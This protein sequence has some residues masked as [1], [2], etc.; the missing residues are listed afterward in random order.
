MLIAP[1]GLCFSAQG[2][3]LTHGRLA[4]M[5]PLSRHICFAVLAS[6]L[7]ALSATAAEPQARFLDETSSVRA[8][9]D[10]LRERLDLMEYVAAWKD[11]RGIPIEAAARERE[12]LDATVVAAQGVGV[13]PQGARVLFEFQIRLAREVQQAWIDRW[14][15]GALRPR[16]ERDLDTDLR[17]A[18]DRLGQRLLVQIYLALPELRRPDFNARYRGLSDRLVVNG[19]DARE[20]SELLVLLGRVRSQAGPALSRIAASRILRVGMTGDYAPFSLERDGTLS[21][22]DVELSGTL[23]RAFD[24][25]VLFVRT[26]WSTLMA[27]Y[28]AGRFDL[29]MSGISVTQER[30]ALATFSAPYHRGGKTPIVRCGREAEFDT[31]VEIDRPHVRTIV[32]PGGTNERFARERLS[33]ATLTVHADN[34]TI[35]DEIIRDRADV[36]VTDDIEVE[37]QTRRW[38]ELCRATKDVFSGADK[39]IL[40]PRDPAL[41]A[42]VDRWLTEQV[43]N[44]EVDRQLANALAP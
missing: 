3:R 39:A 35:F 4:A 34:R 16:V 25:Q 26:S 32:N 15:A 43:R 24:A 30:A 1:A 9:V 23:A 44:G 17:P 42:K 33:H 11:A 10:S 41:V 5:R 14:R 22:V 21:G 2:Q 8:V 28:Q 6:Y 38:P 12:V 18:L 37:L 19:V 40:M 27:D 20:A 13:E 31:L 7:V 36:M 29:A